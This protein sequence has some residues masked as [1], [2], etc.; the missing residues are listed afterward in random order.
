MAWIGGGEAA[1][2][3]PWPSGSPPRVP[4]WPW[5][6]YRS[7]LARMSF[8]I[9][10]AGGQALFTPCDVSEESFVQASIEQTVE[11][12]GALQIVVN[13]AGVVHVEPLDRY[14]RSGLGRADG[15]EPQ[16]D[17]LRLQTR[18]LRSAQERRSYVV[19]VGSISSF[20]GQACTPAYTASKDAVLGLTPI[21]RAG[22]RRRWHPLQLR[23]P[24]HH[25]HADA[26]RA[27]E[28]TPD[29]E[30]TPGRAVAARAD[31]RGAYAATSRNPRCF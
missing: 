7:R 29:P 11:Q 28:Q 9:G 3:R 19:N 20:V 16:V 6:T 31:G 12:F 23:L 15:R 2:A 18:P 1:S 24:G 5:P 4:A 21:D 22:L 13:C 30:A 8:A 14:T 10:K 26:P 27:S 17:L 25:R